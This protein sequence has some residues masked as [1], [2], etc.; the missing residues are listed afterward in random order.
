MTI[1]N[2]IRVYREQAG[3]SQDQLGERLG[4]TRQTISTWEK[5]GRTPPVAQ[6]T[7]IARAL[8]IPIDLL[9]HTNTSEANTAASTGLMFR[10]DQPSVLKSHLK[11]HLTQ[12][13][14][15]YALIEELAGELPNLPEMRPL[16]GYNDHI[17]E[18]VAKDVRD[19]LGVGEI[20]PLGDV[21]A[22]LEAKGL[23]VIL[24]SLPNE[25][26]GFSAYTET[27]G[28]SIIINET[29][30]TERIFFTALHEL[31][32]LI[33]HR[34][35]YKEAQPPTRKNDPREKAANHLAG[36]VLLSRD[37]LSRELYPY[38]DR[39]IPEPLLA[40]IKLRYGVSLRTTIYRAAQIGIISKKQCGQQIGV[41]NKKYGADRE[42][43]TL[44]KPEGLTRLER[45]I[46]RLLVNDEL[47]A[48]RAAEVLGTPLPE[49]RDILAKWMEEDSD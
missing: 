5:G 16:S 9:L 40:D 38:R 25:I 37:I 27:F 45:L 49:I 8:D 17:V 31:G 48:S 14:S 23:K 43:P 44:A 12:K 20:T 2:S 26:S 39:W 3:L 7:N 13:A 1:V 24:H 6:L 47:T 4:V 11:E 22:H 10:A 19:W 42:E 21:L 15:D 35:E 32:H 28:A 30:P 46:Y 36:A 33:F 34:Q 41:L 29:H 18:E